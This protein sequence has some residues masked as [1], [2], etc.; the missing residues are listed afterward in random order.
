VG[1]CTEDRD[2]HCDAAYVATR[3][4]ELGAAHGGA[5]FACRELGAAD[6]DQGTANRAKSEAKSKAANAQTAVI[7][8]VQKGAARAVGSDQQ[9]R[10]KSTKNAAARLIE[11]V[12]SPNTQSYLQAASHALRRAELDSRDDYIYPWVSLASIYSYFKNFKPSHEY[13]RPLFE[14]AKLRSQWTSKS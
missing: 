12:K 1:G 4:A 9:T 3:N 5:G 11:L 2:Q 14:E 13:R 8:G 10:H 6:R 7:R